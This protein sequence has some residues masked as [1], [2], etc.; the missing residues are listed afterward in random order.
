[1][2]QKEVRGAEEENMQAA[3]VSVKKQGSWLRLEDVHARNV[4]LDDMR[5]STGSA[6]CYYLS[7]MSCHHLPTAHIELNL[8][9][10]E[11]S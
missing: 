3:A 5:T 11:A 6:F 1:M 8:A 7:M 9:L 2:V 4:S 10:W